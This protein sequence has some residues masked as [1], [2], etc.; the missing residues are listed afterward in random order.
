MAKN[1]TEL[2]EPSEEENIKLMKMADEL[3][4]C[5]AWELYKEYGIDRQKTCRY[6]REGKL[7]GFMKKLRDKAGEYIEVK[8]YIVKNQALTEYI[9]KN[10]KPHK[11]GERAKW[12]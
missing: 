2:I 11:I 4:Y 10:K 7:L 12:K 6:V 1:F 5:T 3:G 8:W 9:E